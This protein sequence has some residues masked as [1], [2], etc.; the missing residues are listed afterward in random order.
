MVVNDNWSHE[1][2]CQDFDL[3]A[4]LTNSTVH[5]ANIES[6]VASCPVV[7]KELLMSSSPSSGIDRVKT[8][9][10]AQFVGFAGEV[11]NLDNSLSVAVAH[12][13]S[14]ASNAN[15]MIHDVPGDCNC[16]YWSILY[17][18]KARDA[19]AASFSDL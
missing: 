2:K 7:I 14:F 15:M 9:F 12:L 17:Q 11:G 6:D 10:E 5:I 8:A 1:S 18:L 13:Q 3:H 16:L 4:G 19:C